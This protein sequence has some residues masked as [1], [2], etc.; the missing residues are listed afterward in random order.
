MANK[1]LSVVII[2][3]GMCGVACAVALHRAG[4]KAHLYEA[5]P[6]FEEV[7]AGVGLGPNA[8]H[9]LQ[10]LG[11]L[12]DV[13]S[14]A[15]PPKL[16]MRPY[17]FISG[18]GEHEHVYDYALSADELGLSIYRP[19]F[20]DALI[21]TIDPQYTHFNMRAIGVALLPSGKHVVS[22][23]DGSAV[24]ADLV[25]GSDGIKSTIRSY[26]AGQHEHKQLASVNTATY[27]ALVSISALKKDGVKTDLT[28]PL[29]W[30]GSDR[31][32]VTYPIR[33]NEL[34]NVGLVK[35]TSR[36]PSPPVNGPWVESITREELEETFADWGDDIKIMIK[37]V[38]NPTKWHMHVVHPPL[39]H[40][41]KD[42][43]ALVGDAAH[44]MV[45]H[46][47]AGVGQGFEDV[48]V[49][50]RL[51][52]HPQTNRTNLQKILAVYDFLRPPRA[53]MVMQRSRRMGEIYQS[54]GPGRYNKKDMQHNLQGMW[55]PVWHYNIEEA[56]SKELSRLYERTSK[57]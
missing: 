21:P 38:Q 56:V 12:N 8:V 25:I 44:A 33:G 30:V 7:G 18:A 51:L 48:Y 40:Y 36:I 2:G 45:P 49:L 19:V 27:R 42:R 46:L 22:F 31:H 57:L 39:E 54:Y 29:L 16:A 9:A 3:G 1:D 24:E 14:K 55:E 43:V 13:L 28:R 37:H 5:A 10:G 35:V 47:S 23:E 15:D 34:L 53:N 20:L 26:V 52:I 11:I 4:L 17:T 6:K 32:C 50:Y 41:V